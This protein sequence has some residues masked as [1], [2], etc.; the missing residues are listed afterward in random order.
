MPILMVFL[1][2]CASAWSLV[3]SPTIASPARS[4]ATCRSV[5]IGSSSES[6]GSGL[7]GSGIGARARQVENPGDEPGSVRVLA[8]DLR[9]EA[10]VVAA[11]AELD[12]IARPEGEDQGP[13]RLRRPV[14][15]GAVER[16]AVVDRHAAG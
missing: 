11:P 8:A 14:G 6:R 3:T 1:S 16:Q 2:A 4:A 9:P 12:G 7:H 15:P 13:A 10:G 5:L